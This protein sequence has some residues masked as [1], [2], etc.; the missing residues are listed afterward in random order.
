MTLFD[1]LSDVF[2]GVLF[3]ILFFYFDTKKLRNSTPSDSEIFT[4]PHECFVDC[5]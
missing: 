3:K 2:L 5:P 4:D 1:L